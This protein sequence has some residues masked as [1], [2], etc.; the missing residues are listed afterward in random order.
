[1]PR[2]KTV[3]SRLRTAVDEEDIFQYAWGLLELSRLEIRDHKRLKT[4]TGGDVKNIVNLLASK[5]LGNKKVS[6][7]DSVLK[8]MEEW[9]DEKE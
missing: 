2:R 6:M 4:L 1:M 8:D 9:L 5:Q 3:Q 7:D